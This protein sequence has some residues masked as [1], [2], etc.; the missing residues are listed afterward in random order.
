MT[1]MLLGM[2]H[3]VL[4]HHVLGLTPGI[5]QLAAS[6]AAPDH[7]V[8]T[9]DLFEGRT[10]SD[11]E[12]GLQY[13]NALGDE[14]LLGRAERAC[15]QM[16]ADVVYAGL[17]L[18]VVAAQHL[19]TNHPGARGA[20]LINGFIDPSTMPGTWPEGCPVGVFAMRDDPVF[21]GDGD[22]D[23]AQRSARTHPGTK[24]HLYPGTGHL[25]VEP[26]LGDY[27]PDATQ[28]LVADATGL[29]NRRMAS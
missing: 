28:S 8:S 23:A 29:V 17:S 11:I 25:F 22:L 5:H 27:D 1:D 18:G 3:I 14:A 13:V 20:L 4:F 9:P 16:S 12:S 26:T 15:A 6:F 10:F 19:L 7:E 21:V 2:A 24:I